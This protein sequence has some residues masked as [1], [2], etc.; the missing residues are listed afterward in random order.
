[1]YDTSN[2]VGFDFLTI[3]SSGSLI[4][5]DKGSSFRIAI[6]RNSEVTL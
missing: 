1:M 5:E 2:G 4:T 3:L 6:H